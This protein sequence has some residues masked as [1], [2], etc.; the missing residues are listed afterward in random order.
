MLGCLFLVVALTPDR[1]LFMRASRLVFQAV[2]FSAFISAAPALAVPMLQPH[3]AV[4]DLALDK[5]SDR[6]GIT[7]LTGRMVYEFNGSP[8]DGYTV[9]FRFVT[10]ITT[11]DVSRLTDQQTTTYEDAAGKTFSFSTK[12]FVDQAPDK[13]VKGTATKD[14]KGIEVMLEKPQETTLQLAPTQ[15]P[16]Q[17]LFEMIEKA[18]KGETFYQTSL[19]DG[20]DDANKVMTT[21]VVVGK[22]AKIEKSDPELLA[23]DGLGKDKFWPVDIAYFDT[24]SPDGGEEVPQYRISFKLHPNGLTRDL[25]MDYGDFSM[26]GKLVNLKLFDS[27]P[28][29]SC[30]Q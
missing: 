10:R 7:G 28:N 18:E 19:F 5:A 22:P 20:S 27:P 21:T 1:S 30:N 4:Y 2:L 14:A 23:L 25:V 17:H 6:S 15:F 24:S 16:T 11:S 9:N 3:R 29:K 8:C 26:T 12:S 13:E